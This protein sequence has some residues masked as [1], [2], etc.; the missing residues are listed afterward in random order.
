[1]TR[2]TAAA[3]CFPC[4]SPNSGRAHMM[5][6]IRFVAKLHLNSIK[7]RI[8][9]CFF[10]LLGFMSVMLVYYYVSFSQA[11][12]DQTFYTFQQLSLKLEQQL[13]DKLD[14]I[15]RAAKSC[16]YYS[17]VQKS[18]FSEKPSEK[19]N[20]R[21]AAREMLT[22]YK[23]T[24]PYI[25]DIF[26]YA[27]THT[28]MYTN[29]TYITQYNSNLQYYGL[30][31]NIELKHP[32]YSG[33]IDNAD[34]LPYFFYYIPIQN[35]LGGGARI[36]T[37]NSAIC[38]VLCD[39]TSLINMPEE[40]DNG[41]ITYLLAYNGEIVNCSHEIDPNLAALLLS[42]DELPSHIQFRNSKYYCYSNKLE[43]FLTFICISDK[44][45]I[46]LNYRPMKQVLYL[47]AAIGSTIT[48]ILLFI[49]SNLFSHSIN[50]I[51]T[52]LADIKNKNGVTRVAEPPLDELNI[53]AHQVNELLDQLELSTREEKNSR[54]R[55]F[56]AVV[57]QKE[58]EMIAYRNQINP[59]FLFNT[60]ECMRSMAQYYQV[61][62]IEE[63]VTSM[64][65]LFRYS[66]YAPKII[67]FSKE[68]EHAEQY[69]KI[70]SYRYS[71]DYFLRRDISEEAF[72]CTTPSMILQPLVEN[73]I[74]HGFQKE[75]CCRRPQ[76]FLRAYVDTS[77]IFHIILTD[78][79][80]GISEENLKN[81][82][83]KINSVYSEEATAEKKDSIG[84]Q[85]IYRRL[86][87]S[88]PDN[89]IEIFSKQN[90]YT[91]IKIR[92]NTGISPDC[93]QNAF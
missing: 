11:N 40:Q 12:N 23:D 1:M 87:L 88:N 92:I 24:Y 3:I 75:E 66:L 45:S 25:K 28:R 18:L 84:I 44:S 54:E 32:F 4:N 68:V 41:N 29:T 65:K 48:M 78:N 73:C 85:N 10:C 2:F 13:E 64:A 38:A 57:A 83:K 56:T 55:L 6:R 8:L 76:I 39:F 90:H 71:E 82:R 5:N 17:M 42:Y 61:K 79:G 27:S 15:D 58:A 63:I 14:L 26:L 69:L 35:I 31:V 52:D 21:S 62:P 7:S 22:T 81:I 16:G 34:D 37:K 86:T 60:M 74:K 91:Q 59:H 50:N 53:L 70:S 47:L 51:L 33:I 93:S 89:S 30:D 43:D 77:G 9:L 36:Q 49:T 67:S 20:C 72:S 19:L 46:A 80:C